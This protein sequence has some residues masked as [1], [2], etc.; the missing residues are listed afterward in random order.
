MPETPQLATSQGVR[1][2]CSPRSCPPI[3]AVEALLPWAPARLTVHQFS[4]GPTRI[5]S[6]GLQKPEG[7]CQAR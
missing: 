3:E 4:Q 2:V 7:L 1:K 5:V 6:K